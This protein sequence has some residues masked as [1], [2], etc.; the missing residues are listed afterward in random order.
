MAL[1]ALA[2]DVRTKAALTA[3]R[4]AHTVAAVPHKGATLSSGGVQ[5]SSC[6]TEATRCK[7]MRVVICHLWPAN[8]AKV[9]APSSMFASPALRK[10]GRTSA[11]PRDMHPCSPPRQQDASLLPSSLL[12]ETAALARRHSH[13]PPRSRSSTGDG[14]PREKGI[15]KMSLGF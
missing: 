12:R 15:E 7:I 2:L 1:L 5:R 14:R 8:A 10:L 3:L 6:R 4:T 9:F 13:A 11:P